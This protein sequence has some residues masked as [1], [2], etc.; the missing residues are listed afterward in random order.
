M[1]PRSLLRPRGI[2]TRGR[3]S[4][5]CS[6]DG[7]DAHEHDAVSSSGVVAVALVSTNSAV[8]GARTMRYWKVRAMDNSRIMTQLSDCRDHNA[9]DMTQNECDY[10]IA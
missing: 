8:T 7:S 9:H 10:A 1:L 2:R 3:D 5:Q 4:R 6:S